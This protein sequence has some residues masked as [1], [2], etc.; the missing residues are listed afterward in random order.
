MLDG[1]TEALVAGNTFDITVRLAS[2]TSVTVA[3]S[4]RT[5]E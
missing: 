2:G 5:G 4:V 1:L 3:V